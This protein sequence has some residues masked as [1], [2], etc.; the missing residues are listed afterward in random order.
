MARSAPT[1]ETV[2]SASAA[3]HALL[4][5]VIQRATAGRDKKHRGP[6]GQ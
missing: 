6:R 1:G 2:Q 5:G 4:V 3:L